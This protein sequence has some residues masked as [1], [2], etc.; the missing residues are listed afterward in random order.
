[1]IEPLNRQDKI[2][3]RFYSEFLEN[4][5]LE[6]PEAAC[7]ALVNFL[8]QLQSDPASSE[9]RDKA[10][11]NGR[12]HFG[13]FFYE[14]YAVYWIIVTEKGKLLSL[15]ESFKAVRIEVLDVTFV[16]QQQT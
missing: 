10:Q 4:D 13:Y 8:E 16:P 9:I 11:T 15:F 3:I 7:E 1:V 2:P 6:L 5:R 14:R 12:G